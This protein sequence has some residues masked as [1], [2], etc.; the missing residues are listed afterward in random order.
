MT[1]VD[2]QK[3]IDIQQAADRAAASFGEGYHCAEAVVSAFFESMGEDPTEAVAHATPFGGG[4][5]KSLDEVCGV[6]SGC[7]IAIGHVCGRRKRGD[8]WDAAAEFGGAIRRQFIDSHGS[9]NCGVLR[10]QFGPEQQ[11]SEC[12]RLVREGTLCLLT[13]YLERQ[14]ASGDQESSSTPT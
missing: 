2:G 1:E 3:T 7:L 5:G 6:L 9:S 11:M 12:R 4:I 10:G 8:S 14:S 13:M